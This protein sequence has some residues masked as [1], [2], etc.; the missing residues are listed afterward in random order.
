[1]ACQP[2]EIE[3]PGDSDD[4]CKDSMYLMH[5]DTKL[6]QLYLYSAVELHNSYEIV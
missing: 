4:N 3:R 5:F 2:F 1:M 6:F